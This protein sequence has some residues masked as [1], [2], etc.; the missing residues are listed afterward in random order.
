MAAQQ[1]AR[2]YRAWV[3]A[4]A[5]LAVAAPRVAY[6]EKADEKKED[7]SA[8]L[9]DP[10]ALERGAKALREINKS[11]YAKQ[12]MDLSRQ[13]EVTKQQES[14]ER[15]A[16]YKRQA[17]AFAKEQEAVRWEEQRKTM[18][19][20][21]QRQA[22]LAQYQD[23][24]ARKRLGSEHEM[25]RQRNAELV[26]MQEDSSGRREAERL[27]IE[28][29]IQ[30]ERR[31]AEQYAADLQKQVQ[32]EKALAEAQGRILEARENEDLHRREAAQRYEA[33]LKR[34]V[35]SINAVMGH[36][37]AGVVALLSDGNRLAA[38]VGGA[39]ALFLGLYGAREGTRVFGKAVERWLGTPQLV[40]ETS[41]ARWWQPS[42]W[43][44]T[45]AGGS[46]D[47]ARRDFADILLPTDL[48]NTVRQLAASAANTRKHGAPFRHM[49]FYGPPGTG[50][51]M[52]AKRLARTSGLD[53]AILSGGDVAPLEGAAVTQLHA[54]FDWAERSRRGLLLFIDEADAFLGRRS[55]AMSE[56]LR[57]SLNALLYRTGDQSKDFMVVLATN[58][59]GD[60]DDAVLDR[61]DEALEFPLPDE[62]L[63]MALLRQYIEQYIAK[64]GTAQGGAGAA[65]AVGLGERVDAFLRGR[66]A[67]PDQIS[68]SDGINNALLASAARRMEGFSAREV[69]KFAASLQAAVYGSASTVL[70]PEIFERVLQ[71]KLYE[72]AQVSAF[73]LG[74]HG[75]GAGGVLVGMPRPPA[76]YGTA[77]PAPAA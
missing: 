49:L 53:Y 36:V 58:R 64:A 5:A 60:L 29:Q 6:A 68:V 69:A 50:K 28:Q 7:K 34:A 19:E 66:R 24:L 30:A 4:G 39:T 41:R 18:Q 35:E 14:K 72:H 11:P 43:R 32:K 63:R 8:A 51:T 37:G 75:A 38:A 46:K 55:D 26:K 54:A 23:E 2:S 65:A 59:P 56:G 25:Q 33:E 52:V 76:P 62:R 13:Q 47:A 22:Q 31:A 48:H 21:A 20:E 10:E 67:A 74:H 45:P 3:L 9:F 77:E 40:R 70:T 17:A 27:R 61:M 1:A 42:T 16:D 12:V 73:K 15:E 71:H 57:G 44:R